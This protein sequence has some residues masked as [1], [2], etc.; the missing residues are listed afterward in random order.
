MLTER[1]ELQGERLERRSQPKHQLQNLV[2]QRAEPT[3]GVESSPGLTTGEQAQPE[4]RSACPALA[5]EM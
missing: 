2:S 4:V 5:D 3:H 1:R